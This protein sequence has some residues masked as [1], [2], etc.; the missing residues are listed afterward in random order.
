[1]HDAPMEM[2][3]LNWIRLLLDG[4]SHKVLL[5]PEDAKSCGFVSPFCHGNL[6]GPQSCVCLSGG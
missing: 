3:E 6:D 1:L 4:G 2:I 5:R